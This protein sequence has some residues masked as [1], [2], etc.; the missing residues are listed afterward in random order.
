M[1]DLD[2]LAKTK[3]YFRKAEWFPTGKPN[4]QAVA[5]AVKALDG[6]LTIRWGEE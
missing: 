5:R 1:V 2:E 6:E 3:T 4:Y